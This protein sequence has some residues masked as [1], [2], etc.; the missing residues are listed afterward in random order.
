MKL[1]KGLQFKKS[2]YTV[3]DNVM[4]GQDIDQNAKTLKQAAYDSH[5]QGLIKTINADLA[6]FKAGQPNKLTIS[7]DYI[8]NF[9]LNRQLTDKNIKIMRFVEQVIK[10]VFYKVSDLMTK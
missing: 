8:D 3:K 1:K 10:P 9:A 2:L 7:D 6:I 5:D 4:K